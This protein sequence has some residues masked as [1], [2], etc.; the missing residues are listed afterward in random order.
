MTA[1]GRNEADGE[2][3]QS[4][5]GGAEGQ[6]GGWSGGREGGE[7]MGSAGWCVS[8]LVQFHHPQTSSPPGEKSPDSLEDARRC[9]SG[10][11]TEPSVVG[12]V[13]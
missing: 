5:P 13:G 2:E 10:L 7:A 1:P 9:F 3:Q 8:C 4:G 11:S 12:L 6:G